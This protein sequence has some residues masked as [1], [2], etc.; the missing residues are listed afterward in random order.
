MNGISQGSVFCEGA[1]RCLLDDGAFIVNHARAE[2]ETSAQRVCKLNQYPQD[3]L[4]RVE[5]G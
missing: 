1:S 2:P 5:E 4:K 3:G